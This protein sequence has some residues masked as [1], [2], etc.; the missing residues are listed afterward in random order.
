MVAAE[1]FV[2]PTL[3]NDSNAGTTELEPLKTTDAADKKLL[4]GDTMT[5]LDGTFPILWVRKSGQ[6]DAWITVRALHRQAA[7]I[8]L[9]ATPEANPEWNCVN[10]EHVNYLKVIGLTV[11]GWN[12]KHQVVQAG[13]GIEI[14]GCHHILI[15]D[16][17]VADASGSGIGG[18][19]VYWDAKGKHTGPLDFI[20]LLGNEVSGCA[21]WDEY[22]GS[23]VSLWEANSAGLGADPSG[24]NIVIRNNLSYGN[25][26]RVGANGKPMPTATDGNGIILD[27]FQE[28]NYP[29]ASLV[30]G[31]TV[32]DNG[33]RGITSTH[34][35]N[36]TA[37]HNTCKHDCL[38]ALGIG[39]GG[40]WSTGELDAETATNFLAEDNVTVS[41]TNQWS[42]ALV[43]N[44]SKDVTLKHNQ[45]KGPRSR[46][47]YAF[48]GEL[49]GGFYRRSRRTQR[50]NK[51]AA[52]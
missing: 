24:Y 28:F 29:Y 25:A 51:P 33:G 18:G 14:V 32:Y 13:H 7:V 2:S 35:C 48:Y 31:N 47:Q 42:K 52:R 9:G 49:M 41:N 26:N 4:P 15:L 11:Q 6:P 20:T 38:Y 5:L 40:P 22:D 1:Y 8:S 46:G 10:L 23:G 19:P 12:P 37:R 34:T 39:S 50:I 21:F 3:G 27:Y 36:W 44:D 16:C 43:L 17:R 30:E 45:F